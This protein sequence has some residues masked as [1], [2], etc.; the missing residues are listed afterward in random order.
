[1]VAQN[2]LALSER[3]PPPGPLTFEEF[4]AWCDEDSFAEWVDG[5]VVLLM[6]LS[7][8]DQRI[9]VF[10]I[11]VLN[12][13]IEAKQLGRLYADGFLMRLPPPVRRSRVPDL[14]FVAEAHRARCRSTYVD[15]PADLAVE[16]VS[17]D[18]L[19]RDRGDKYVEYEQA[20]VL[21]YWLLDPIREQAEFY[22]LGEDGRYRLVH[23]GHT[24]VYRSR[25]LA[26]FPLAVEWLW[27]DPAP[28][29]MAILRQLELI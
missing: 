1:M 8:R 22:E 15:G 10:L 11:T 17:L 20:G 2:E 4:L 16:I 19:A 26:G 27:Q 13:W 5:Q 24:G 7:D 28:S 12:L 6:P 29:S 18:S 25:V 14:L 9:L 23:G 21:E 3:Q